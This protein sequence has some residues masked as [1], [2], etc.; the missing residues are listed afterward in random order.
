MNLVQDRFGFED[1]LL[2]SDFMETYCQNA[3][4]G[5]YQDCSETI[6]IIDEIQESTFVYNSIRELR[7]V[8]NCDMIVS[9]SYLAKTV[10]SKDY[11]LLAGIAYLRM[12]P[13]SL[14]FQFGHSTT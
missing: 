2:Q 13:L 9:G 6:L 8:L 5:K 10:N 14:C 12:Q 4:I 3:G 7:E 11:F 1:L